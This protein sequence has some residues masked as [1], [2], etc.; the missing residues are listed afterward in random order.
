MKIN[1][2]RNSYQLSPVLTFQVW[3]NNIVADWHC[4]SYSQ[5][6]QSI[7]KTFP[8]TSTSANSKVTADV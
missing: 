6:R 1:A 5:C 4:S 7:A 8:K 3:Q 2:S